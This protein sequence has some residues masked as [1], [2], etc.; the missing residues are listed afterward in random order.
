MNTFVYF[1]WQRNENETDTGKMTFQTTP[2]LITTN[3]DEV[4]AMCQD[5]SANYVFS[6]MQ[7]FYGQV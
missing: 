5:D 2:V 7:V 6:Y 1:V 3:R 4:T